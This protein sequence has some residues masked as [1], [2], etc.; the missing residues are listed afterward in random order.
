MYPQ[1]DRRDSGLFLQKLVAWNKR[2]GPRVG[3][4]VNM[5]DGRRMR[6]SHDWGDDIQISKGGSFFLGLGYVSFSG[7]LEPAIDKAHLSDT[8][9]TEDGSFW[10]F[11]H[12]YQ[13]AHNG[14]DVR[15]ACRVFTYA[16]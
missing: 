1:L 7:G 10:F 16:P 15:A 11:H 2:R 9:K 14:V 6:F 12:N 4:F 3:D 8:G 13:T 5:P